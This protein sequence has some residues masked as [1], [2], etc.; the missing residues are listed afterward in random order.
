VSHTYRNTCRTPTGT[1]SRNCHP[2]TGTQVTTMNRRR[3]LSVHRSQQAVL[4]RG[5]QFGSAQHVRREVNAGDRRLDRSVEKIEPGTNADDQNAVT[6]LDIGEFE[7]PLP[8]PFQERDARK[9]VID[10]GEHVIL[11]YIGVVLVLH[12]ETS[13]SVR[14]TGRVAPV[15][16]GSGRFRWQCVGIPSRTNPRRQM[17]CPTEPN[18][19]R[20][21]H[22]PRGRTLGGSSSIN[23]MVYVRGNRLDYDT[24]RDAHGCI[25]WGYP[26]L[27]RRRDPAQLSRGDDAGRAGP[28]R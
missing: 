17:D 6:W 28:H 11:A 18:R 1:A 16:A 4:I 19:E 8:W 23:G 20:R 26:D 21:V 13:A 27:A 3:T 15:S 25:G 2:A 7:L 14:P 22:W 5:L 9:P 24:W 10:R 12:Q